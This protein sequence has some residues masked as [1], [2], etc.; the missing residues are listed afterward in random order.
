MYGYVDSLKHFIIEG[1]AILQLGA[2]PVA[3]PVFP[4]KK[5]SQTITSKLQTGQENKIEPFYLIFSAVFPNSNSVEGWHNVT[6]LKTNVAT[7]L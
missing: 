4:Q 7:P 3:G 5:L 1:L 6:Y 2:M